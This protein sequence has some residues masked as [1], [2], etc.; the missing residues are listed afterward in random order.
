[1]IQET[2]KEEWPEEGTFYYTLSGDGEVAHHRW[3]G[4]S[5]YDIFRKGLNLV[6]KTKSEALKRR[7]EIMKGGEK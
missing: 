4:R 3:D 7:D 5:D 6:F 2:I 1:M